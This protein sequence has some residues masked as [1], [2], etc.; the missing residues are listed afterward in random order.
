MQIEL[1]EIYRDTDLGREARHSC[2][3]RAM[4]GQCTFTCVHLPAALD[5]EWDGPRRSI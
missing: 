5:D 1:A 3:L 4:P 2:F